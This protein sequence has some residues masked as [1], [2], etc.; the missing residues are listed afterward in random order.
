MHLAGLLD[1]HPYCTPP[2]TLLFLVRLWCAPFDVRFG[3]QVVASVTKFDEADEDG[4]TPLMV[5]WA[6]GTHRSHTRATPPPVGSFWTCVTVDSDVLT[7]HCVLCVYA[8]YLG[9]SSPPPTPGRRLQWLLGCLVGAV[10]SE[11]QP[12]DGC[13]QQWSHRLLR[14]MSRWALSPLLCMILFG[15]AV[16]TPAQMVYPRAFLWWPR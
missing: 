12:H 2:W 14:S 13:Q 16:L 4:D 8:F 15:H 11:L 10:E 3:F 1:H 7:T 6:Q 9:H 5:R